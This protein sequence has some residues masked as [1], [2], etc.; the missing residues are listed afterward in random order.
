[1]FEKKRRF[2]GSILPIALLLVILL[3]SNGLG[4]F[5]ARDQ[6]HTS[7]EPE[8]IP[9]EGSLPFARVFRVVLPTFALT[10]PYEIG[11]FHL[12]AA[13]PQELTLQY[14]DHAT[15]SQMMVTISDSRFYFEDK[16]PIRIPESYLA[17]KG[18]T[19]QLIHEIFARGPSSDGISINPYQALREGLAARLRRAMNFAASPAAISSVFVSGDTRQGQVWR[20]YRGEGEKVALLEGTIFDP[21]HIAHVSI[22]FKGPVSE[23]TSI[24]STFSNAI[25]FG[26]GD[27]AINESLADFCLTD[28]LHDV[29]PPWE[30]G[31]RQVHLVACLISLNGRMDLAKRLYGEYLA[32]NDESGIK[33]LFD[34]LHYEM[35]VTK[36]WEE[37]I[38]QMKKEN[39]SLFSDEPASS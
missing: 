29:E 25:E 16:R 15:K 20:L 4:Y 23:F 31:C 27:A 26:E 18:M 13:Y 24:L 9:Q 1:M 6:L 11:G 3:G 22:S 2:P 12:T 8:A 37:L 35:H 32:N 34:E 14:V 5:L 28:Q 38:A 36:G 39:P 30:A 19:G 7:P 10:V 21:N 17:R 33:A